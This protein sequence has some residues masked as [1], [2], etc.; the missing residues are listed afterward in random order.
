MTNKK[1]SKLLLGGALILTASLAFSTMAS[2]MPSD[3]RE[4]MEHDAEVAASQELIDDSD[5]LESVGE[6]YV[7]TGAGNVR[8]YPNGNVIDVLTPGEKYYVTAARTDC[9]WY[10]ITGYV[11]NAYV[12]SSFLVPEE[13]YLGNRAGGAS[14]EEE[15]EYEEDT[16]AGVTFVPI[17]IMMQA[18]HNVNMRTSPNGE[19]VGMLKQGKDIH[20]TGN[21]NNQTWYQCE[22]KGDIV[23]IYD[24]YLV[25]DF[26]QTMHATHNVNVRTEPSLNGRIAAS[27][28][29]GEKVKVSALENGWYKFTYNDEGDIGYSYS[30]YLA[31]ITD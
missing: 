14:D 17:D 28:R 18:T 5:L 3:I 10:Q 15:E 11:S 20:V 21:V 9:D 4:G 13:E 12:F 16:D 24:D 30:D 7:A 19:I 8:D 2:A 27:L 25:P 6:Y 22:Y 26:P 29:I 1:K 31:A 23:Y